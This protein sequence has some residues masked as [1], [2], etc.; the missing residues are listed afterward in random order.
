MNENGSKKHFWLYVLKLEQGKY[1][2]GVTS[3][4]PEARMREHINGYGAAWTRKYKPLKLLDKK[5]LGFVTYE[6]AEKYESK[7]VR[8]YMKKYGVNNARGGDLREVDDLTIRFGWL[9][10]RENWEVITVIIFLLLV[11]LVLVLKQIHN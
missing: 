3:K 10:N 9:I 4:T 6:E 7:V 5:E 1:Y 8:A 11:I 2:V